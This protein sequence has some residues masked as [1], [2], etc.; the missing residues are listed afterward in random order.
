ME[1][2]RKS[3][4]TKRQPSD[5]GRTDFFRCIL[6][7]TSLSSISEM[8]EYCVGWEKSPDDLENLAWASGKNQQRKKRKDPE[9]L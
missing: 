5:I 2:R 8:L 3:P 4:Q 6:C 1:K 7:E 9:T